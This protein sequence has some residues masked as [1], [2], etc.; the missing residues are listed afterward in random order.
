MGGDLCES[1]TVDKILSAGCCRGS[2]FWIAGVGVSEEE[3]A[4]IDVGEEAFKA[5]T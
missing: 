4:T 2:L 3:A 5:D 1:D